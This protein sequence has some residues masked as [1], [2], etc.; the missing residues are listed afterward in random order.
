MTLNVE[1]ESPRPTHHEI[2]QEE[3]TM[4]HHIVNVLPPCQRIMAIG[5]ASMGQ[6]I[7]QTEDDS[8]TKCF[9]IYR[10]VRRLT[11]VVFK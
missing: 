7:R 5:R 8:F 3:Q 6:C 2:L 10:G 4:T 1:G 9:N 11:S